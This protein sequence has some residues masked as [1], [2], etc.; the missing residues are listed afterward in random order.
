VLPPERQKLERV[1]EVLGKRPRLKLTVHGGYE[2]TVDGGH[3]A[4]SACARTWPS[5]WA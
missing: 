1:A 3:C 2:A 4:R 5:V